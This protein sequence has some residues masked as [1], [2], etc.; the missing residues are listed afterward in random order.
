VAPAARPDLVVLDA[1]R[2]ADALREQAPRRW[3]LRRG[4][5]VAETLR[6]QR[7]SRLPG[8]GGSPA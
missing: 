8:S 5:V 7:L 1:E 6:E 3:V 2:E 4:R